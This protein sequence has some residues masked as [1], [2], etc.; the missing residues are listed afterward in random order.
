MSSSFLKILSRANVARLTVAAILLGSLQVVAVSLPAISSAAGPGSIDFGTNSNALEYGNTTAFAFGTDDFTIEYWWK[1]NTSTRSDVLDFYRTPGLNATRLILGSSVIGSNIQVY[2]DPG[3]VIID[4]GIS[5]SS[6]LNKWN[7]IALT[8][9]AAGLCLWLN[10]VKKGTC[11]TT[12]L[13]FGTNGMAL[14]VMK[15]HG[16]LSYGSGKL[17]E[18]RVIKG[19]AIYADTFTPDFLPLQNVSG[20]SFLLNATQGGGF[21]LDSSSNIVAASIVG[22]PTSSSDHPYIAD[23]AKLDLNAGDINSYS[24]SGN[25]WVNLGKGGSSFNA[26]LSSRTFNDSGEASYFSFANNAGGTIPLPVTLDMTWGIWFKSTDISRG[27]GNWYHDSP[28]ISGELPGDTTDFGFFMCSGKL[29]FGIGA[30]DLEVKTTNTYADGVWHYFS[31]TRNSSN[32]QV[33]LYVDGVQD[34]VG[35]NSAGNAARTSNLTIAASTYKWTGSIARIQAFDSVL[36]FEQ[37]KSLYNATATTYGKSPIVVTTT[38]ATPSAPTVSPIAGSATSITVSFSAVANASSYTVQLFA[39]GNQVG[40][41]KTSFTS[42]TSITGLSSGTTYTAKVIAV[43]DGVSYLNSLAS[44]AGSTTTYTPFSITYDPN[45]ATGAGERSSD[46]FITGGSSISLP[47][48]GTLTKSGYS[49]GGWATAVGSSAITG[50]Y[51]PTSDK[52]LFAVWTANSYGI[53]WNDQIP[54]TASSGGSSSYTTATA[55]AAIPTTAPQKNGYTFIGWNTLADGTGDTVTAGSY[56]PISPFGAKTI[57]AKWSADPHH[58][59]YN[60]NGGDSTLPTQVDVVTAGTFTTAATPTKSNYTFSGWSN[61][62]TSTAASTS[63]TMGTSDLTLTAQWTPA[64]QVTFISNGSAVSPLT[65]SSTAL[66]K[67]TDPT[68]SGYSFSRWQD[69]SGTEIT[70]PFTPT[71]PIELIAVWSA[72]SYLVSYVYNGATSDTSTVTSAFT[73]GD[74]TPISLPTPQKTGYNFGG[75]YGE[76]GL[77]NQIGLAGASYSPNGATTAISLFAK[78]IINSYSVTYTA[79]ANGSITGTSSQ[80]INHGSNAT[81]VTATPAANHH[82]V[83]WSDNVLTA[84]RTDLNVVSNLS[85]SATFAIDTVT[86]TY[87]PNGGVVD[88]ATVTAIFGGTV[89]HSTVTWVGYHFDGWYDLQVGGNL[90]STGFQASANRQLWA[91]WTQLSLYGIPSGDLGTPDQ[92]ESHPTL[93]KTITSSLDAN[94]GSQV[95]IP[96]GAFS[97]ATL[98]KVYTLPNN[99]LARA[100]VSANDSYIISQVVAWQQKD[101]NSVKTAAI[102]IEMIITSP[103][104]KR[105]AVVYS[106]LG[107]QVTELARATVDGSVTVL[108]TTDPAVVVAVTTPGTPTA[109]S[110]TSGGNMTSV[111]TWSAPLEDG[112]SGITGYS[113]TS[114]PSVTPPAGCTNVNVTSCTFTGLT[115]GT[116]YTFQVVAINAIG[117]SETSTAS[118]PITPLAPIQAPAFT[119]SSSTETVVLGGALVGYT[120][121]S[122]GGAIASYAISPVI[123]NGLSFSTSTGLISG[124]PSNAAIGVTYTISA[125]NASAPDASQTFTLT[126]TAPT[127][128]PAPAPAPAPSGGGGGGSV[129]VAPTP[130]P[131]IALAEAAKKKAEAEKAELEAKAAAELKAAQERAAAEAAQ[132]AALKAAQEIADAQAKAAAELKAAQDKAAEDARIAEELRMAQEKAEADLRAAAEKKAAEDAATA[133]ALANKKITPAVTLY[134][135]STNLKLSKYDSAYLK[136]FVSKLQPKAKVTCVGYIYTKNNTYAKAKALATNQAKAVCAMMKLQKKTIVT[137]IAVYPSKKAPKAA[138]GARWVA[139]NYRI[140]GF[141]S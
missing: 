34:G 92:A 14:N 43:G 124:T 1:P 76:I 47:G 107:D 68:R 15:D 36:T 72:N 104:I 102:A 41:D 23:L 113:V 96:A 8:R 18:V 78:W 118:A 7:H 38:L 67:P 112:G 75:W 132:A 127:P 24:K 56:T 108:L 91:R 79:G 4:S 111:V 26:T 30:P 128:A 21:L 106:I 136:K 20:T 3:S 29:G 85:V 71:G 87:N 77:T 80:T 33:R 83:S 42:G 44:T 86:V 139:V 6:V 100:K 17:T 64:F 93:T 116:S 84:G 89:N 9:S 66:S 61:G 129:Y 49:F 120:I 140:D 130:D 110:A 121:T 54:T 90:V 27:C 105:G 13:N 134:S 32:G 94:T 115:N 53:N 131:A 81:L 101:D 99:D 141:K 133:L 11:Y 12:A 114:S 82:F 28:I 103:L 37:I 57:Y 16:A 35:T 62:A 97:S 123:G 117:T 50:G 95:R 58:V 10:G 138:V 109:V 52:N 88:T 98:V 69:S 119:I 137:S 40:S 19:S 60:L 65:F 73:T 25:T 5:L 70:W 59:T 135:L 45:G 125:H 126:V 48:V 46:T 51:T 39:G 74:A 63:Y 122:T 2:T 55:I 31:V 22:P